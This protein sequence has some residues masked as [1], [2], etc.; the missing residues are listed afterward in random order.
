MQYPTDLRTEYMADPLGLDVSR[1]RLS[2]T[3]RDTRNDV[4]QRAYQVLVA[5]SP[6]RLSQDQGDLWD[7]GKVESDASVHVEYAGIPLVSRQRAYWKVRSW[8]SVGDTAVEQTGWSEPG[9]FETAFLSGADWSAQWIQSTVVGGPRTIPPCPLIRKNFTI[10]KSPARARLYITALGLFECEINGKRVCDDVFA[11]GHSDYTKHVQYLT[12]DVTSHL[13]QGDNCLGAILADGWYSGHIHSDPRMYY[14]DRPRLLAQLEITFADG[15]TQ[16]VHSDA[17][18]RFTDKGPIRSSDLIQGED[19]DARMEIPGWSTPAYDDSGWSHVETWTAPAGLRLVAKRMP[20]VRRVEELSPAREAF[21]PPRKANR[22][23]FDLGQ[24]MVGRVRLKLRNTKPGQHIQIRHAE[25]LD[26]GKL[27][28]ESLRTARATDYYTCRG[29]DEE[30]YEPR[31]TF[32]GFR[33][34]EVNGLRHAPHVPAPDT[35][36]GIVVHSDLEPTGTF[37]CSD[38]MINQL[39]SNIRW[40]Q[41]GNFL[42]IPTDCPQRDERLGWTGDAQVFIRTAAFNMNVASFFTKWMQDMTDS[43]FESGGIPS[44]IPF[45]VSI[46]NEGGA[47]WSDA[48]IICPWTVWRCFGDTRILADRYTTMAKFIDYLKRISPGHIRLHEKPQFG[49]YGDWLNMDSPTPKDYIGTAYFAYCC[50]LM[51]QIAAALGKPEDAKVYASLRDDVKHAFRE[52]FAPGGKID[53]QSQTAYVLALHF[54]L[55]EDKDRP[56]AFDALVTDIESRGRHLSTGFVGTP[57]LNHVLTRFGRPD[58]AFAL[59]EQKTYPSWLYPITQ[60]ATTMWER[61]NAYTHEHGFGDAA[62]NS[63]NHYAYGAVGDWMYGTLAGIDLMP[64]ATAFKHIHIRPHVGGSLTHAKATLRSPYGTIQSGWRREGDRTTFDIVIPANTDAT[65]S[66][67]D[68]STRRVGS[69]NYSF[70]VQHQERP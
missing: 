64:G 5:S 56:A 7:S 19:Y 61:W 9:R 20:P 67:P 51:S 21:N 22:W 35:L 49:G 25:M 38:P 47:A 26:D 12:Y 2:W 54:D 31:F 45:C 30:V 69:G 10:S 36:T 8:L 44:T 16:V 24:N 50:E 63:Y 33:Y 62:M 39:Q 70:V 34:V 29:A 4:R 28:V 23:I 32:H 1:P 40:G 42:E 65:I 6:E 66:L 52:R 55:L 43:Q 58:L 68:G 48:V 18:W 13:Q 41:K 37:E 15:S 14:G 11:P 3:H 60:G 27:Y 17:S 53:A 46:P 59:L 57:Y